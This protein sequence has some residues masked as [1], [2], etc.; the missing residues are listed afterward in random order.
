MDN[1]TQSQQ[2][3]M[4]ITTAN[5]VGL[6]FRTKNELYYYMAGTCMSIVQ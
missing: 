3:I 5:A 2:P 6:R 4:T 1:I